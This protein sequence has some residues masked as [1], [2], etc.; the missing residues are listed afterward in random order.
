VQRFCRIDA[1]LRRSFFV[2]Q[3]FVQNIG[4][5]DDMLL[6]QF[7]FGS[8]VPDPPN[9]L[10][11]DHFYQQVVLSHRNPSPFVKEMMPLTNLFLGQNVHEK[12]SKGGHELGVL[13]KGFRKGRAHWCVPL[14]Q[15][16]TVSSLSNSVLE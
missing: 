2:S 7:S 8:S 13:T 6:R 14:W 16:M 9:P 4:R 3:N 11:L 10:R 1:M 15:A 12:S 5:R